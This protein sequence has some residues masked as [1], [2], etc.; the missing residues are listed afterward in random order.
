MKLGFSRQSFEKKKRKYQIS[1]KSVQWQPSCS[2]RAD[3][4]TD[5]RTDITKLTVAFR[6]FVNAP[7]NGAIPPLLHTRKR[8]AK[9]QLCM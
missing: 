5:V 7:K 6:N 9:G 8:R 2:M 4:R 1:S 3:G